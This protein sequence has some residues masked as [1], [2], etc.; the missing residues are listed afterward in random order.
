MKKYL[1]IKVF[2][3]VTAGFA[4]VVALTVGNISAFL[5]WLSASI[6]ALNDYWSED[7]M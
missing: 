4:A 6:Y 5:G 1:N 2:C 3:M 7:C